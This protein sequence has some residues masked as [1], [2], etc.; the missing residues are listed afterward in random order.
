MFR[1]VVQKGTG[2]A[3]NIDGIDIA[4]KTGTAQKIIDGNYSKLK[5]CASFVGFVPA[6]NPR[7][8]LMI[9]MDAP[10]KGS[11]G[12]EVS[13]PIFRKI[14]S[15]IMNFE[16]LKEN[17][18]NKN[19]NDKQKSVIAKVPNVNQQR[20]E[21]AE[22]LLQQAG[23][24]AEKVGNGDKVIKQSPQAN[25]LLASGKTVKLFT[26]TDSSNILFS[27]NT[28][29]SVVGL[30][31]REAVNKLSPNFLN[32]GVSGKGIVRSQDPLPGDKT[33]RG[34]RCRLVCEPINDKYA[35]NK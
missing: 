1:L 3:A 12:G 9:L 35:V 18:E 13:A 34:M 10:Q 23:Y 22:K 16:S 19:N 2:K 24:T 17:E 20:F 29:P 26:V 25:S 11:Y 21:N 7:F 28:M 31:L 27:S 8:V 14:I 33:K 30:S 15:R 6:N 5:H 32:I 4:G